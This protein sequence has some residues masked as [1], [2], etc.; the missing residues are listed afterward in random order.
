MTIDV[1]VARH[2]E[3]ISWT[4]G[5]L[6]DRR[7]VVY[8]KNVDLP[9]V[10]REAATYLN[11]IVKNRD[12]LADWTFFCQANPVYHC[13]NFVEIVNGFPDTELQCVLFNA[14]GPSFYVDKPV[15]NLE[16]NPPGDDLKNDCR[17]LW[18]GLF[19]GNMPE[20]ILFAP[21]SIFGI[22][23]KRLLSRSVNFYWQAVLLA[24]SRP[25]GPWEFERLWSYLWRDKDTAFVRC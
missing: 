14:G 5:I 19:K 15:R 23:R 2:N 20:D 9:N 18:S 12:K 3:D 21:C 17:G 13:R 10:G 24:C 1:I 7:L 6:P 4:K 8:T 22:S 11:H 16:I 25:R